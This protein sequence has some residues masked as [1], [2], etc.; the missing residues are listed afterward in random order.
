MRRRISWLVA[1]H[2]VGGGRRRSSSRCACWCGP[3]PRTGPW[4]RP[5]RRR[6]T[7]RSWWPACSTTTQLAR[8]G[9]RHS[10]QR[11]TPTHRAC[12]PP[13]AACSGARP[14]PGRRPG[15][16]PGPAGEAFTVVEDERRP[17]AAA[18][19][20]GRTA[21]RWCARTVTAG[22]AAPGRAA[23]LGAA[24]S[25][26]AWSCSLA[27]LGDRRAAGPPD[28]RAAARGGRDRPPAAGGRPGRARR[29]ARH[30]GDRRSWPRPSTG[31][32]SG[33]PSCWPPSG[34]RSA[35][36]PT[37]C[38]PRSPR[39]GSTPRRSP[40]R[41]WPQRL[42]RARRRPSSAPSTRSSHEARRPVRTD[43]P[44]RPA[45]PPRWS[46]ARVAFWRPSPR[47][48]AGPSRSSSPGTA[49]GAARAR[50]PRRPR[51]RARSTTSSPT[52]PSARRCAWPSPART[53]PRCW[54]CPTPG[55]GW[56][57]AGRTRPGTTGL[58][59]DIARRAAAAAGGSVAVD[60]GADGTRVAVR[61]PLR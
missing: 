36:S 20:R 35:T 26:S 44:A 25:G 1:R 51:R 38:A 59:L 47:T 33:P 46:R 53:G 24:S 39:C 41:S 19:R 7:S 61:L 40:S 6:A 42:Q 16:A 3:S 4:P 12:S 30:R 49:R 22:R 43:L 52:P 50:R 5:T 31:S 29:G 23:G 15:G 37:G 10:T 58:G 28:Q 54:S 55:R 34:P 17:G 13:T 57:P 2:D 21:P 8:A 48:R 45:T 11:G 18:G 60:T 9:R 32:P 14:R 27:A 56:P